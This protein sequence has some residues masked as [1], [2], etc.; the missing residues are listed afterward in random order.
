MLTYAN[1][2]PSSSM[3]GVTSAYVNIRQHTSADFNIRQHTSEYVSILQHTSAY[4]SILYPRA[5][6]RAA[7]YRKI[8]IHMYIYV[9]VYIY[10]D[11][12]YIKFSTHSCS[13]FLPFLC[14]TLLYSALLCFTLLYCTP[15]LEYKRRQVFHTRLLHLLSNL[16]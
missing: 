11:F 12:Q 16:H 8:H 7:I 5:R 3:S 15:K 6:V 13:T 1:T 14:C 4:V 9:C 2:P 10:K